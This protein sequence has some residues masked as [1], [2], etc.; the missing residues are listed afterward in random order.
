[1]ATSSG[2][3]LVSLMVAF[4]ERLSVPGRPRFGTSAGVE[5]GKSG[6]RLAPPAGLAA[7][8]SLSTPDEGAPVEFDASCRPQAHS[9][10]ALRIITRLIADPPC[11]WALWGQQGGLANRKGKWGQ[12]TF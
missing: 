7:L 6:T 12:Y 11:E 2:V 5:P 4:P 3:A 9:S 10:N 8:A 1:M